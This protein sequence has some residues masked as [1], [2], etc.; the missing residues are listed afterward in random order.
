[1]SQWEYRVETAGT[2]ESEIQGACDEAGKQDW[3]L[4]SVIVVEAT[5]DEW[6]TRLIF[7]RSKA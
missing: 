5:R 4:V 2:G 3:E 1:M 6:R 7:K